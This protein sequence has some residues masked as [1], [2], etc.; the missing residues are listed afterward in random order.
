MA[1]KSLKE[2]GI[3]MQVE[4]NQGKLCYVSWICPGCNE[5]VLAS[6]ANAIPRP[7]SDA[8]IHEFRSDGSPCYTTYIGDSFGLS[9]ID[10]THLVELVLDYGLGVVQFL[11]EKEVN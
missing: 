3:E 6:Q 8:T 7:K 4:I 9:V 10:R 11:G 2:I 5:R 1:D